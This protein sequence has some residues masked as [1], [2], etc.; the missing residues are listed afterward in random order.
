MQRPQLQRR[1]P[2][3]SKVGSTQVA[4]VCRGMPAMLLCSGAELESGI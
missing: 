3:A 1:Q 4:I 2:Q